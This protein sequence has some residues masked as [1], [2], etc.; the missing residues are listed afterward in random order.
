LINQFHQHRNVEMSRKHL[1]IPSARLPLALAFAMVAAAVPCRAE[2]FV[3]I[4]DG[5]L[6]LADG[7]IKT[8]PGEDTLSLIELEDGR[9]RLVAE[10]P[11]PN[12]LIGP[13]TSVA[14][15]PDGR[16]A[17]VTAGYRRDPGDATKTVTNDQISAVDLT[18]RPPRLIGSVTVGKAP[19]GISISGDGSRALVANHDDGTVS[20][21]TIDTDGVVAIGS[22]GL[23]D[24][25]SGPM[26]AAFLKDGRQALVSRDGDHRVSV[27]TVEETQVSVT[28]RDIYPGQRPDC[29]D[30]R[31]QGDLAVVANIGRGQGD[32]DTI[33]LIDLSLTPPRVVDTISV[34]QTPEAAFFSPDGRYVGV[35]V[36]NGTN[37]P[38]ASPFHNAKGMF[39]LLKV[40]GKTL[41]KASAVAIGTWTQG[42]AFSRD[43]KFVLVQNTSE[44]E[45]ALLAIDD[46]VVRDTG[47]RLKVGG[48][49]AAIRPVPAGPGAR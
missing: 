28:G 30:V 21:L 39:V 19:A 47:Q 6:A 23:G 9:L 10:T 8:V 16:L 42:L 20:L 29:V 12:S 38:V 44:G 43:G 25:K 45:V 15:T 31:A 48:A 17:L 3:S 46:N 26:H 11:V 18:S 49:P 5:K 41:E 7:V 40:T 2:M 33:S 34:G 24:S 27:L 35:N 13:P 37:K 1:V 36:I 4:Q 22:F 32:A 14:V